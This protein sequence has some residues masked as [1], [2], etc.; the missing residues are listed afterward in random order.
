MVHQSVL[1]LIHTDDRDLF[2]QQLHFGM[3]PPPISTAGNGECDENDL[4]Y[5]RESSLHISLWTRLQSEVPGCDVS[6]TSYP[7]INEY[8]ANFALI[9]CIWLHLPP[10][11]ISSPS[12]S[13][14]RHGSWYIRY[15]IPVIR[16]LGLVRVSNRYSITTILLKLPTLSTYTK[17]HFLTWGLSPAKYLLWVIS[18]CLQIWT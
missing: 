18:S 3:N 14:Y 13:P 17:S 15:P 2:R 6:P 1:D 10:Q 7:L 16:G 12:S 4:S 8:W 11:C 5:K 9:Y